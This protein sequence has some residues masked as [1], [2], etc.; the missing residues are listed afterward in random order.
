MVCDG[1]ARAD[2]EGKYMKYTSKKK[3]AKGRTR[4]TRQA[5]EEESLAPE[6]RTSQKTRRKARRQR[7]KQGVEYLWVHEARL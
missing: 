2:A 5:E 7:R 3:A 6:K 4:H 1:V